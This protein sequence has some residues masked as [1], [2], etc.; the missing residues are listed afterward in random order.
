[1]HHGCLTRPTIWT[2]ASGASVKLQSVLVALTS[3]DSRQTSLPVPSFPPPQS[4][5]KPAAHQ[6][7]ENAKDD[8]RQNGPA[9]QSEHR[10]PRLVGTCSIIRLIRANDSLRVGVAAAAAR[11]GRRCWRRRHEEL[12]DR[13][14]PLPYVSVCP[15]GSNSSGWRQTGR[16][17][18]G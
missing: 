4:D 9:D 15:Y 18:Q 11:N 12:K 5:A 2:G 17:L 14:F 3:P 13:R 8:K 1:M 16:L 6:L 7:V 10:R